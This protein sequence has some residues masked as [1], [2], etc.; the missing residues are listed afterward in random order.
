MLVAAFAMVS[1]DDDIDG[2]GTLPTFND[3]ELSPSTCYP[4]D[5]VAITVTFQEKGKD[6]YFY[7]QN[8]T[9]DDGRILY[10]NKNHTS[11]LPTKVKFAAPSKPGRYTITFNSKISYTI[12][13]VLFD[14]PQEA[15]ATLLVI[16]PN[17]DEDE[18]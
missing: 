14:V 2:T 4:E 7:E 17:T 13:K 5:S 15:K 9:C 11:S 6:Y 18:N 10:R 8:I 3:L 1:C 16:T 12:G